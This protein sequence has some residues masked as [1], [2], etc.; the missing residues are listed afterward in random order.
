MPSPAAFPPAPLVLT[1]RQV[2]LQPLSLTHLD[3]LLEAGADPDIWRWMPR[4]FFLDEVLARQWIEDALAE[5]AA[6]RALPF[7]I[8]D[9]S[10]GRAV[11]STRMFDFRPDHKALEI[12]W[13]W[14]GSPYQR[15]AINSECKRLLLGFAFEQLGALRVQ[16]KTDSRNTRSRAAIERVGASFEG[17]L[18]NHMLLPS[19]DLRHSAFFSVL[20]DEWPQIRQR[21]DTFLKQTP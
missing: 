2:V 6:K 5:Q 3:E 12:G 15:T 17:V 13:T 7:A 16:F 19:G 20:A 4:A 1:G 18:R 14:L 10:S 11:G 9:A 8:I 21:L